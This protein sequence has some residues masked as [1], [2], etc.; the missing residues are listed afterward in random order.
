M[1]AH[2]LIVEDEQ[3][4]ANNLAQNLAASGFQVTVLHDGR[5]VVETVSRQGVDI[6][7]LDW[8]LPEV[9]GLTLCRQLRTSCPVPIIMM[10]A[11]VEEVDRVEG[12][13]TGADDYLCKPFSL[14]EMVARVRALLRRSQPEPMPHAYALHIDDVAH[15]VFVNAQ[16]VELTLVEYR[17]LK[18]LHSTPGRAFTR[19]DLLDGMYHDHRIVNDRTI[20]VHVKNLRRKLET[21]GLNNPIATIHGV[22]YRWN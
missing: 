1:S 14:R 13:E 2:V 19:D 8:L 12:L 20:N 16:E 3:T 11:K 6:V 10:T 4:L 9:D 5:N 18:T 21:Y 17:L 15:R 22:G 7:L